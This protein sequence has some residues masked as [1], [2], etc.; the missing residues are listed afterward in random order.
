M[1]WIFNL[2]KAPWWGGVFERLVKSMKQC[3]RKT[4]GKARLSYDKLL[5]ATTEV[6]MILNSRPI[7]YVSTEDIEKP[8]TPSHLLVGHRILG[9]PDSHYYEDQDDNTDM[10]PD[11]L[12]RRMKHLNQTLDHFWKSEYLL[13]LRNCHCYDRNTSRSNNLDPIS[14]DD[15]VIV[16]TQ[17]RPRASWR[18]ARVEDLIRGSDGQVR[19]ATLRVNTKGACSKLLR[20]PLQRIYP[21]EIHCREPNENPNQDIR[22]TPGDTTAQNQ[23]DA[24]I[25]PKVPLRRSIRA[26]TQRATDCMRACTYV[27]GLDCE[28]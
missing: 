3:L 14:S 11:H 7:S 24:D 27:L 12:S 26:A 1:E 19:G 5:T 20:Q 21:L 22:P 8:L 10:S 6:E 18:L 16:H 25:A 13:E 28:D 2:E 9:L 4:I 23:D 15:I 17:G